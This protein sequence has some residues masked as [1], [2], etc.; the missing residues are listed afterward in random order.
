MNRPRDFELPKGIGQG[1]CD[2]REW[3]TRVELAAAYRLAHHFGWSM[4]IFN[5]ITARVPGTEDQFLINNFG[6]RYDEIKA[7]NLLKIDLDGKV[8]GDYAGIARVN[9]AGY[10]IHS[11]IHAARHD[12][13]CV[14][15]THTV[16][17][18]AVSGVQPGL[19]H[20]NQDSMQLSGAIAYHEFE[21]L[22]VDGEEKARLVA[23]LGEKRVMIL[24][25][26]GLLTAGATV[27]EA[28][29]WM[30]LLEHACRTQIA[31]LSMNLPVNGAGELLARIA[32]LVPTQQGFITPDGLGGLPYDALMRLIDDID[33]SYRE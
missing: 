15:H 4:I 3:Q 29:V 22:A 23:D 26:H 19:M 10:V 6:L 31:T 25:N 18:C 24:R 1:D 14:M 8:V 13:N 12:L 17:G 16:A 11:A 32:D 20:I 2:A 5:H 30:W 9:L 21:G 33:P 28:F 27:G 7:S